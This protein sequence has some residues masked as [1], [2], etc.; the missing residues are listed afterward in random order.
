M[1]QILLSSMSLPVLLAGMMSLATAVLLVVTQRWHGR[2]SL[3]S[4]EGIQKFHTQPTA[5]VGGIAIAVGVLSG[6][7]FAPVEQKALLGPLVLAGIPAFAFGL[8]EDM[9]KRVSVSARLLATMA[10][11]VLAWLITDVSINRLDTPVFD[12]LLQFTLVSVLFTA[13]ALGGLANAINIIDGFN[14]LAAGTAIIMSV[15]FGLISSSLGDTD[16]A[17]TGLILAGAML[18][19]GLVNWPMGKLF[20]GDGGAYFVGFAL[21]WLAVLVPARHP[22]VS[23]WASMAVCGYP[24]LEVLFSIVRRRRRHMSPGAPDR[25]HLHSLVR[26]RLVGRLLPRASNLA[27]NSATGAIMWGA[28][29]LPASIA[30]TAPRQ[31]AVL[32]AGLAIYAVI[33]SATYARLTQFRWCFSPATMMPKQV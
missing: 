18:G 30:V 27:R 11:G 23:A 6:Y 32:V 28:A 26:R 7:E 2:L 29:L 1:W 21:A 31:T 9:T 10:G 8:L 20:L 3:D 33:Y 5:R 4:S 22:E 17:Y 15:S 14:G 24:V 13:F 25:L 16:L 19:F 12:W